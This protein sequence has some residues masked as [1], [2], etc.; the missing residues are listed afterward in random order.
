MALVK[1][2]EALEKR[3]TAFAASKSLPVVFENAPGTAPTT[4]YIKVTDIAME[5][6]DPSLGT[7]H[8]RYVG[9]IRLQYLSLQVGKGTR[10]LKQWQQDALAYFPR[11]LKLVEGDVTVNIISTGQPKLPGYETKFVYVTVDFVYRVDV[12]Q[13]PTVS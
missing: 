7:S 11:G 12:I 2:A 6:S 10:F 3:I 4:D 9:G 13:N 8:Q 5:T 1:I